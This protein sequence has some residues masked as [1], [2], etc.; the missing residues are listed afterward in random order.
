MF[1][2]APK[3]VGFAI[4]LGAASLFVGASSA[5]A[6][7][8]LAG[9]T[10]PIS[11]FDQAGPE[12][13]LVGHKRHRSGRRQFRR[14]GGVRQG[15]RYRGKRY[16]HRRAGYGYNRGGYWYPYAWWLGAAAVGAGVAI[17]SQ[18]DARGDGNGH[19]DWCLDRYRSYNPRTDKF[20]AY[21]GRYKHC[22]SPYS[23]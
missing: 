5:S 19:V 9:A 23:Y 20:L 22:I 8:F 12:V 2:S 18:N 7:P 21:S 6:S 11:G 10:A 17:A 14:N 13:Q 1:K 3:S 4:A 16:R 15:G